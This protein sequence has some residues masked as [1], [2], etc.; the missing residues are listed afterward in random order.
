[1]V[2]DAARWAHVDVAYSERKQPTV[3]VKPA[4]AKLD[5]KLRRVAARLSE[6]IEPVVN[7][8]V[9][10]GVANF[11][12]GIWHLE[13]TRADLNH[14]LGSFEV[15]AAG[16]FQA[17]RK[18]RFYRRQYSA[19]VPEVE[20]PEQAHK[21]LVQVSVHISAGSRHRWHESTRYHI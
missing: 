6:K 9:S 5:A 20:F 18:A 10:K 15:L 17:P 7:H 1:M 13:I 19:E 8:L 16:C 14:A 3:A 4:G 11:F 12:P 2:V 21:L